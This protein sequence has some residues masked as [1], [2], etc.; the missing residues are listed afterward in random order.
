M[1]DWKSYIK[2]KKVT[3]M[4]LGLLGRALGDIAF[5]A[6][7]G[8]DLIVTDLKTEKELASSLA[9]LSQFPNIIYRLGGHTLEDFQNRDFILKA[10]GVPLDSPF[11]AE[12]RRNDIPIEMSTSLFA[13]FTQAMTIGVTGTR[14]KSTV[15]HLLYDILK[16]AYK[17]T[18]TKVFLGGNVKGV[19][20]L[21]YLQETTR[22]D[23]VVMELDSWQLQGFGERK[24]SPHIALFTTFLPDHLNYYKNDFKAYFADKA[25]IFLNQ[26]SND[27][28]IIGKTVAEDSFFHDYKDA[29]K[30]HVVVADEQELPQDWQLKI[31]GNHNRGNA[32]LAIAAARELGLS[33]ETIRETIESFTGVPGRL[34]FVKTWKDISFYNDTTATTPDATIVALAALGTATTNIRKNIILIMGGSDKTIDMSA[35][36]SHIPTHVKNLIVLPGTGT[37]RIQSELESLG[38]PLQPVSS[39]EEAVKAAVAV[40]EAGDI[41]LLSPAFAS[42]G[43]FKNEFDRAEQFINAVTTLTS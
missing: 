29:L 11:I 28:L 4:G 27:V 43:L 40:A 15:T 14:G 30:S 39:M 38:L 17:D 3:V 32:A 13:A 37:T 42:F 10:A 23:I 20:T 22:N 41:I 18:E 24:I 2:G 12:A 19:S 8:A 1:N 35:L 5:L 36:L 7:N 6:E 31:P 33:L 25:N 21:P 26:K 34:E 9:A 16:N